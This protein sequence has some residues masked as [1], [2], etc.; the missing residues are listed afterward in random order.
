MKFFLFLSVFIILLFL[1]SMKII[2]NIFSKK[3]YYIII[4]IFIVGIMINIIMFMF[5]TMEFRN[6][7]INPGSLGNRG[8][9]GIKGFTGNP[10]YCAT[11]NKLSHTLGS[12]KIEN[13]KKNKIIISTPVLEQS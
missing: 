6:I 2:D 3:E 12:K 5:L 10:D 8:S 13:D 7:K 9:P 1:V 4:Q 11:C